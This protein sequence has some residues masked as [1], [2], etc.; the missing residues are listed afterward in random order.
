MNPLAPYAIGILGLAV[1]AASVVGYVQTVRLEASQQQVE[2]VTV[3]RD[4][5]LAGA[6]AAK[7][8]SEAAAQAAAKRINDERIARAKSERALEEYRKT[9]KGEANACHF[10]VVDP[11]VDRL[12]AGAGAHG[13]DLH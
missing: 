1:V 11:S 13:S 6:K 2:T 10:A 5:A 7:A 8:E 12:L 4:S 3:E 9:E